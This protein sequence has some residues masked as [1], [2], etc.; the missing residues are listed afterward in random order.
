MVNK[1]T[2]VI[3]QHIKRINNVIE[4][5]NTIQKKKI[6]LQYWTALFDDGFLL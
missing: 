1:F 6:K 3:T 4:K 5:Y 2:F